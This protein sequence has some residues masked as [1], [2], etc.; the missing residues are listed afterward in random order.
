MLSDDDVPP[1]K[2]EIMQSL[3]NYKAPGIDGIQAELF[4]YGGEEVW[5]EL[6]KLIYDIWMEEEIPDEWKVSVLC[7]IYKKGDKLDC[8]N[9]RGIALLG[10]AYKVLSSAIGRRLISYMEKEVGEYQ[11]GFR[12]GRSTIDQIFTARQVLEKSLE[13]N[14]DLHHL[15]IDFQQAYDSVDRQVLMRDLLSMGVSKKLTRLVKMTMSGT[16]CRVKLQGLLSEEFP[17]VSGIMQGDTKAT[18]LFNMTLEKAVRAIKTNPGGTIFDRLTQ[19]MAYADDVEI[20]ARTLP[21]LAG[22]LKEFETAAA[23]RGLKINEQKTMYMKSTRH[24]PYEERTLNVGH[25][26]FPACRE[27]KY[28]GSLMT[29]DNDIGAEIGARIAAGSRCCSAMQ[30]LLRFRSLSRNAKLTIY[31]AIIR[32][33]VTYGSETWVISA[34]HEKAL[35]VWE[36]KILRRIYGPVCEEGVWRSRYNRELRQLYG[37]TDL[38]SFIKA[39]RIRW[40]GHVERMAADRVPRKILYGQPGGARRRGRPPL[41]WLEDVETDVRKL[42][43]R[44]WRA[45]ASDRDEWRRIVEKAKVPRGL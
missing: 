12:K 39:G 27:F 14:V 2:E 26:K 30:R 8:R 31:K 5:D 42:G 7:P 25:H 6:H 17:V 44:R 21:A 20:V 19:H 23:A 35:G 24:R 37:D 18:P 10:I 34:K 40:L 32:P 45:A 22:A 33:V 36:R 4:K 13:Y 15:Y 9:Y 28:L 29:A 11:C 16:R 1:D 38:V 41:R 43:V 3:K